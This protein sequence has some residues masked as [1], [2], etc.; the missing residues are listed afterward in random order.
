CI[1]F[2]PEGNL[3][4]SASSDKTI[5]VW[6]LSG[7]QVELVQELASD[8]GPIS[9]VA[10]GRGCRCILAAAAGTRLK[11]WHLDDPTLPLS[12]AAESVS[13]VAYAPDGKLVLS[14]GTSGVLNLRDS[15]SA[16]VEKAIATETPITAVAFST[17]GG[18]AVSGASDGTISIWDVP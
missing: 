6:M 9:S 8:Q 10:L 13:H 5:R 7:E 11:L 16:E 12:F 18:R 3:F 17:H 15:T 1:S 4:A 14:G 2:S